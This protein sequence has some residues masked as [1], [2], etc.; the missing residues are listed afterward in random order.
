P[1]RSV[2]LQLRPAGTACRVSG[3]GAARA[4]DRRCSPRDRD[5]TRRDT[6][7]AMGRAV[8]R[9]VR[10]RARRDLQRAVRQARRPGRQRVHTRALMAR[11]IS[12]ALTPLRNGGT[13]LDLEALEAY[14]AFLADRGIDGILL[15]GTTGEGMNLSVEE[16]RAAL[17]RAV[18]GPLPVIAHCGAQT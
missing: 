6:G 5:G 7:R 15:C 12:A 11:A 1:K 18:S 13:Q 9:R 8:A 3:S 14:L 16:R 17:A 4:C 2:L 10:R